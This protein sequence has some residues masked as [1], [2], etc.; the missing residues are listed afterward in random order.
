MQCDKYNMEGYQKS[1]Q[2]LIYHSR[3]NYLVD[4]VQ[5]DDLI[6]AFKVS[7]AI[8]HVIVVVDDDGHDDV[9]FKD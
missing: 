3:M 7:Q 4:S 2:S 8:L 1:H 6:P 9:K 5:Y